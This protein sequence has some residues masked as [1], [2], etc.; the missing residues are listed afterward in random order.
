MTWE[1]E[2]LQSME[3]LRSPFMD[4]LMWFFSK[5]GDAGIFAITLTIVLLIISKTRPVGIEALITLLVTFIIANLIIKNMVGRT[6][7]YDAYS[8][9]ESLIG[10]QSDSSFPSGHSAN[11]VAV[12]VAV[13]LNNRKI[14]IPAVIAALIIAFS[15]LYNVVHYP[16]DVLAGIA[17]GTLVAVTVHIVS[18]KC[19]KKGKE[20]LTSS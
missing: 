4:K 12:A 8:F 16:T 17:I 2:F 13:L 18:G 11:N 1:A 7:P 5:I 19:R 6:R 9:L 20:A 15:R 10:R 14:G 3:N